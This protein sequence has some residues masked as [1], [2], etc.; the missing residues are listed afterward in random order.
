MHA[1]GQAAPAYEGVA[2]YAEALAA[3]EE[4]L[5]AVEQTFTGLSHSEWQRTTV[6][7]SLIHI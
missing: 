5:H 7:L 4:G 6:L 3:L 2:S 1:V